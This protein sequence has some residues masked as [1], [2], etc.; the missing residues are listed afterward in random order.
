[1]SWRPTFRFQVQILELDFMHLII[2][3]PQQNIG[4]H[5]FIIG[6]PKQNSK[7]HH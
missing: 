2:G 4:L 5:A 3:F 6:F 7:F 1:M